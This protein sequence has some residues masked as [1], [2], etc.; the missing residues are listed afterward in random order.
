MELIE[1]IISENHRDEIFVPSG[2]PSIIS[3]SVR[4][5]SGDFPDVIPA[6]EKKLNPVDSVLCASVKEITEA[7]VFVPSLLVDRTA[8]KQR[9]TNT[10]DDL[11]PYTLA[12]I[13]AET[14]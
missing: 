9:M 2:R 14:D 8:L 4:L 12:C 6:T 3:S 13:R 1:K 10:I 5:A 7:N 11:D